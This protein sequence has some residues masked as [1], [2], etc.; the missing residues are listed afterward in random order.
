MMN[1]QY[2][3]CTVYLKLQLQMSS[4]KF[5]DTLGIQLYAYS[6]EATKDN[7]THQLC[8]DG[9]SQCPSGNKCFRRST[10]LE[11]MAPA[12]LPKLQATQTV[13]TA[14]QMGTNVD[15]TIAQNMK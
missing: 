4:I 5:P 14:V 11:S 7:V 10:V 9:R 6:R 13:P 12:P 8:F 2:L 1:V 15:M 3:T